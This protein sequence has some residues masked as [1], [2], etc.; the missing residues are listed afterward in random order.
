M[1]GGASGVWTVVGTPGQV[2]GSAVRMEATLIAAEAATDHG[3]LAFFLC[4]CFYCIQT[5][6]HRN[7]HV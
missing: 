3:R 2:Y 6:E 1:R 7:L 4:V 5:V